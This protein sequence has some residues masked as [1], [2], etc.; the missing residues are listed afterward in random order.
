LS[1][2]YF[3]LALVLSNIHAIDI[4]CK[5]FCNYAGRQAVG[6][7]AEV[8][9]L[10]AENKNNTIMYYVAGTQKHLIGSIAMSKY[11]STI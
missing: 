6:I 11:M 3:L 9:E 2:C 8:P 1:F 10:C 7:E 5:S 4:E